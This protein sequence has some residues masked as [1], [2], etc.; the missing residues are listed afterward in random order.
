MLH[1]CIKRK[2][3]M[4]WLRLAELPG[5]LCYDKANSGVLNWETRAEGIFFR[6]R[7]LKGADAETFEVLDEDSLVARDADNVFCGH[8]KLHGIDVKSFES[9]GHGYFRDR[10]RAF[11]EAD[12][13]L[14]ALK[15]SNGAKFELLSDGYA[16]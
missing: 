8:N 16:R 6:L 10:K 9:V 12:G 14:R 13:T 7:L 5:K 3:I 15:G 2:G 1:G 4:A 11:F